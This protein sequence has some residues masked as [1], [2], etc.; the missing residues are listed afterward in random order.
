MKCIHQVFKLFNVKKLCILAKESRDQSIDSFVS[1]DND[2][3]IDS[4]EYKP[5][6]IEVSDDYSDT[7]KS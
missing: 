5:D 7:R 3:L 1:K 6:S 4:G 2:S